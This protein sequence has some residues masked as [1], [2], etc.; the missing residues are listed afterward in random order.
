MTGVKFGWRAP[1]FPGDSS[2]RSTFVDQITNVLARIQDRFDSAWIE[3]HFIPWADFQP[4]DTDTLECWTSLCYLAGAFPRL[5]FGSIV[6]CQSYRNPALLAKMA[7]TLQILSGGRFILGIG[8]GWME[9]EYRAYGY[10]FP[11]APVR[12][13]QLAEAV[14]IIRKM[15]T[16]TPA[17]FDGVYYRIKDAYCEPRPNPLPP[18]M[19]G[20]EGEK[21]ALR[22][23]AEHAD[24]WNL[25][26][27]T[28]ETY[29]GK[30]N[31][32]RTHCEAIGRDCDEIVKTWTTWDDG[33]AIGETEQEARRIAE[34][35]PFGGTNRVIGTPE[36]V[37]D[38]LQRFT[39]LGVRHFM[40][41]F[42]DFPNPAGAEL[43]AESIIPQ[44][45]PTGG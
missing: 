22:I 41:R 14:Q 21:L 7:A 13:A 12:I 32:L 9:E 4:A 18:V 34:A 38:H 28:P 35:S 36:Q 30:L 45:R 16:E 19:I 6:L 24:W 15:W 39:D 27:V 42:A 8:A 40:L 2:R 11:R 26:G 29:A 17:S 31:V 1:A 10:E 5:H 33:I 3:D 44:F 37:A 23:V 20:G 43:F 25:T